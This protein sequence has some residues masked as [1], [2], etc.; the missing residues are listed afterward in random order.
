MTSR[1]ESSIIALLPNFCQE[2]I[3]ARWRDQ[4]DGWCVI[5]QVIKRFLKDQNTRTDVNKHPE[6]EIGRDLGEIKSSKLDGTTAEAEAAVRLYQFLLDSHALVRHVASQESNAAKYFLLDLLYYCKKSVSKKRKLTPQGFLVFVVEEIATPCQHDEASA[7]EVQI[8]L[9]ACDVLMHLIQC[10]DTKESCE[11][12]LSVISNFTASQVL[13]AQCWKAGHKECYLVDVQAMARLAAGRKFSLLVK[14]LNKALKCEAW[15][16]ALTYATC[17]YQGFFQKSGLTPLF[18]VLEGVSEAD[19]DLLESLLD[20]TE[21]CLRLEILREGEG[22]AAVVIKALPLLAP[23]PTMSLPV[24]MFL[25]FLLSCTCSDPSVLLDMLVS[26]ETRALEYCLRG[27]KALLLAGHSIVSLAKHIDVLNEATAESVPNPPPSFPPTDEAHGG[28]VAV[29]P[30]N[31][32]WER[33]APEA[34]E[35][36]VDVIAHGRAHSSPRQSHSVQSLVRYCL[37]L[38]HLLSKRQE[39]GL[40][41]SRF[42]A[43]NT[44]L[45]GNK[46]SD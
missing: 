2:E 35:N 8:V 31:S 42:Q 3:A 6:R 44:L 4:G 5:F 15:A 14:A 19:D 22:D 9:K 41:A 45:S 12:L 7:V 26:S 39:L 37:S 23:E 46:R 34:W 10:A 29:W 40:L 30:L 27:S 18:V 32:E 33:I 38:E 43:L 16:A 36:E 13:N 17:C 20:L 25:W 21:S 11:E 28:M 1:L 24:V